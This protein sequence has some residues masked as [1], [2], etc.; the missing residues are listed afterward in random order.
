MSD[1][2]RVALVVQRYGVE[3]S[4]GAETLAR[5]VA[6]LLAGPTD[7]TVLTTCAVDYRTWIDLYPAG[8][9]VVDGIPV[10]RFPV[11][12]PRDPVAFARIASRAY[13]A[14]A[15]R[16]VGAE[17]MRAQGPACPGL[18][19]HLRTLGARYDAVL[20]VTYL[21]A[22]TAHSIGLVADRAILAP[23]LHDEPPAA[24][25][26]FDDVFAAARRL[27][28]S[29]PEE[30][31]FAAARFGVGADRARIVGA[32][33]DPAPPSNPARG[34][35]LAGGRPYALYVGRIDASK[36]VVDL[37]SHH[38]RYRAARPDGLDLVLVGSGEADLPAYPWVHR[39][40]YVEDPV[41]HDALAGAA[42][43]VV[44]SRY[45]SLS[46]VALEA[47]SHGRPTLVNAASPVLV[48]QSRRSGG[49]LW[50]ADADEYAVM[51]DLLVRARPLA[52]AIGRQGAEY[53]AGA[54][55]WRRV[56]DAWLA[57]IEEVRPR[58]TAL[59]SAS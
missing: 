51:L 17:W 37:V 56:R 29:T 48:G 38:A 11:P 15:D 33:L 57:A 54:C 36:G 47:W 59:D 6:G 55:D 3:V 8:P 28:F 42:A 10:L 45:E 19:E 43:V 30:A 7:L 13:S 4:G 41:K 18:V 50:Y 22:T 32:G 1:R 20:F 26:I 53:V 27:M 5:R 52:G 35:A 34:R 23:T 12:V 25:A 44:P 49:G 24:L 9:D 58:R 39:T 21:Y 46:F 14:P 16:G 40:G 2:A 31:A